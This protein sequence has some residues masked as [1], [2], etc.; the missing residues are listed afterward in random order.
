MKKPGINC[1]L[2]SCKSIKK[3]VS[4]LLILLLTLLLT[5]L[6][7]F[8]MLRT[9]PVQTFLAHRAASYLSRQLNTEVTIGGFRLN[10]FLEAV[11]TDIR[12]LDKHNHVLLQA[13]KIRAGVKSIDFKS[14]NL[15]LNAIAL[16]EADVNLI[17]YKNDSSLNLQFIID[18][19]SSPVVDTTYSEPWLLRIDNVKL[20]GSHFAFRDE[21]YM[22]PGR[23]I[24]FS[25]MDF[26]KL[27]L[28]V[29]NISIQGD[30]I[31]ADIKQIALKEK[32]GFTLDDFTT[33]AIVCP[34][35]LTAE[36]LQI[37]TDKSRLSMDLKFDYNNWNAFN[38]F[39]DS[40]RIT[41]AIKPSQLDMRDI[42]SFA[43]DIHGMADV[44]DFSGKIKGSV[45]SF[46]AKNFQ[47]AFGKHTSF[48]GN[49]TMNGLPDI[50][51][52]FINLKTDELYTNVADIQSFTIPYSNGVNTIILPEAIATLGNVSVNGRFTGFYNDFVSKATFITDI[53]QITTDILLTNNKT[54]HNHE[55]NGE[56]MVK[57]FDAG[58]ML[59]VKQ[60]GTVNIFATIK[61]K[62]FSLDK[63]DLTMK[64]EITDLQYEGNTIGLINVD[65]EF[66]KKRFTGGVYVNDELLS[67]NFLGSADFSEELPAFNFKADILHANL[68]K[69]N[70]MTNDSIVLLSTSTDFRF[71]GNTIDNLVGALNFSNTK[72]I[73]GSKTLKMNDLSLST[74]SLGNGGKRMQVNSDFVN[75]VFSGQ[76]TFDDMSD[77]LT[78]VFTEFLPSLSQEQKLP[79]RLNRGSFDY[80]VQLHHTDSLTA[81]FLPWLKIN[82]QT[83]ISGTFDPSLGLVNVN[84]R[85]PLIEL[86]GIALRNWTLTG[87]TRDKSLA[88]RMNCSQIDMSGATNKDST[89]KKIE[90]FKLQAVAYDDSVKFGISWDD[91][92]SPDQNKG[93]I[94][95]AV[96]FKQNP[97]LILRIDNADLMINDTVWKSVPNNLLTFDNSFIDAQNIGLINKDRHIIFNGTVSEDPLSQMVLDIKNFN[98][99]FA[100][101]IWQQAGID[102]D[103]YVNGKVNLSEL[104]SVPRLSADITIKDFGFNHESLGDA[105][106]KS[107]WDNKNKSLGIDMKVIY[108]GNAGTH[109]PLNIV[110]N[111]YP[112]RKHENFD[113]KA[114]VD[115]LKVKTIEP[116]LKG[117][118]SRM[119]GYTSGALT[120]TGDFSDPVIKGS[121]KLMRTE[122]LVD[123]LRTSYSFTGDFNFDKD[124][125]W[126][127]DIELRDSTFGKGVVTGT[128]Y[129][130]AF[131]DFA[132]DINLKADNLAA[133]NTTYSPNEVYY[134]RAKASGTMTLK[135]SVDDLVLKADMQSEKGTNVVIP[136]SF[137]RSISE[138]SFIQYRK[139][140]D[141]DNSV[142]SPYEPSVLSLQLGLDV[143]KNADLSIILPYNMGTIDV[144]GDGLINMGIDTRGDYSMYGNYIMDNGTFLFNFE[145]ILK[146]NFQIQKGGS[147]TFNGSPYDAD[148][149]LKAVYKVKTSLSGLPELSTEDQ[150]KRINVNCIISLAN[151][152]YNPDI[153]FSIEL[154][155]VTEEMKRSIFS[156]IDTTNALEMNQQMISLLVLNTFSS[157]SGI[158]SAGASQGLGISSYEIISAQLSSLLSKISKDFDIG[159]NYRPGDQISPQ[160]LELAL[161]TQLFDNRVTIDGA[162]GMNTYNN[163]TA[164]QTQ[165]VIGDVLVEVKITEDGRFRFKAFNRT[166]T[167]S[168]VLFSTYSPYTQGV[169]IVFRKEFNGLKDLFKHSKQVKVPAKKAAKK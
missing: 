54:T 28:E 74:I 68:A 50:E 131:T 130:K 139:H 122:L 69:L 93:D 64:G 77:Y 22:N 159:V 121:V 39:L 135:G 112:E 56:I 90:Q 146:K 154:P 60:L 160:E 7:A 119:R 145:N 58:K 14:H 82:S 167:G 150:S 73:M 6:A 84:G 36:N 169:G 110:G 43:P 152:L 57:S 118:F 106:I 94:T 95:G 63:A 126:F 155:D 163:A 105:A 37:T 13:K 92:K 45:S 101:I 66:R 96:S 51:E 31:I 80:T 149:K 47:L 62:N 75:A 71:Q 133:L 113:L 70:L 125:M 141:A 134:G 114:D 120:L 140:G 166:N 100:D 85:S 34:R 42:V 164:N 17:Q 148:I 16:S 136:I 12:I 48:K 32:S 103:G 1:S 5:P 129:H 9:A 161:S 52:T 4:I 157:S 107:N 88:V 21:R 124:K 143:K 147:I 23:G 33:Q 24:D 78:M 109:Y 86:S 98:I 35:G 89:V 38:Y 116:F 10:W 144:Q 2:L 162:F 111:I 151:D 104:Y 128:I 81:M 53:G 30:S 19:F 91:R 158:T 117:I 137:S 115:N 29:R 8:V 15:T 49:I 102:L 40:I 61:G 65:G 123:Y 127:K 79:V 11:I 18:Y 168:D 67:L 25:D 3:P 165:Q 27:N 153:K 20:I 41:A 76:Y 132:L 26:S 142:I 108:V 156:I 99:S 72:F 59:N 44:F 138:N 46:T 83:V 55:Y 87:S 97:R